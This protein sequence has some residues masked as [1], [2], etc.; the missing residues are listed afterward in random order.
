MRPA[1]RCSALPRRSRVR[2]SKARPRSAMLCN[3]SP[4]KEVFTGTDLLPPEPLDNVPKKNS[5]IVMVGLL[6]NGCPAFAGHDSREPSA[7]GPQDRTVR[8]QRH[9]GPGA[10][11]LHD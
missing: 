8:R 10:L 5:Q 7:A 11:E 2:S 3:N 6:V 9:D 4:K 1:E